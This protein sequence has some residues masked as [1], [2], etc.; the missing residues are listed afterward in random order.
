MNHTITVNIKNGKVY[1][2]P[3]P[4]P[5]IAKRSWLGIL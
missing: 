5:N 1:V 3:N 2:N 4:L